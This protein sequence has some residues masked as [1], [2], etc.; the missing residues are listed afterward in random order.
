[1]YVDIRLIGIY[2]RRNPAMETKRLFSAMLCALMVLG[3]ATFTAAHSLTAKAVEP[4]TVYFNDIGGLWPAKNTATCE[5]DAVVDG[6]S[7]V[8]L[9]PDHDN[10]QSDKVVA[11][12]GAEGSFKKLNIE[13]KNYKYV[14]ISYKYTSSGTLPN[15]RINLGINKTGDYI[16]ASKYQ[17]SLNTMGKDAWCKAVFDIRSAVAPE[18]LTGSGTFC[19]IQLYPFGYNS[20]NDVSRDSVICFESITFLA[21]KPEVPDYKTPSETI[22]LSSYPDYAAASIVK[23]H[24]GIPNNKMTAD[25]EETTTDGIS[26]LK[27][28]PTPDKAQVDYV[29]VDG[30]Q[31]LPAKFNL[32]VYKYAAVLYK[33]ESDTP[34]EDTRMYM[35]LSANSGNALT[36]NISKVSNETLVEGKWA[37][38]TFN[39]ANLIPSALNPETGDHTLKQIY[40][41]P[42][43]QTKVSTID[44]GHISYL[45]QVMFFKEKPDFEVVRSYM[46]GYNDSTFRPTNKMTRAEACTIIARISAG[47]DDG[48]PA[49]TSSAYSDIVASGWYSK[50]VAYCEAKGF[51][52]YF[53]GTEF[54]PN[55]NI[56]RAEFVDLV[57]SMGLVSDNGNSDVF[58]DVSANHERYT[59]ITS[60]TSSGLVNGYKNIDGSSSFKPDN[61]I[62][63]AEVVKVIN[64]VLG[65]KV[66]IDSIS[67]DVPFIFP[68]VD[69][70]YWAYAE[71]AEACLNHIA[72]PGGNWLCSLIDLKTLLANVNYADD[73]DFAATDAYIAQLDATSAQRKEQIRNTATIVTVSG[74][75]YYVSNNGNDANDGLTPETAWATIAKVNSASLSPGDGVFFERGG[76]WRG[77]RLLA[78]T[79]VTYSAYGEGQKPTFYGSPENGAVAENWSLFHED[80]TTGKKIWVYNKEFT[81]VGAIIFNEGEKFSTKA[82]PNFLNGKYVLRNDITVDFDI[83]THLDKD[84]MIFSDLPSDGT[85]INVWSE[86]TIGKLYLRC[87]AGN[88]GTV[89]NSIEFNTRPVAIELG[90]NSDVTIDNLCIKYVGSHAIHAYDKT[91]SP[92]VE[93]IKNMTVTNCEIGWIGGGIQS[94]DGANGAVIRFGN[95]VELYGNCNT[96]RVE[97]CYVYQCYDAGMTHQRSKGGDEDTY[98]NNVTYRDNLIENCVYGIEYFLNEGNTGKETRIGDNILI[99]NNIIR[100]TGYGLGTQRPNTSVYAGIKGGTSASNRFTNF[101]IRNN[102]FD[103][104]ALNLVNTGTSVSNDYAPDYD[105]NTFIQFKDAQIGYYGTGDNMYMSMDVFAEYNIREVFGDK[106]AKIYF[107]RPQ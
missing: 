77:K 42:F 68:D 6:R 59:V 38:A 62:T 90:S 21:E 69:K 51:L 4:L 93:T 15:P 74:T 107:V 32:D 83:K 106:N 36:S 71:I 5:K 96:Y 85:T 31:Y 56:T 98:M 92:L 10:A 12:T 101:V 33:Y 64:T 50:Y 40:I 13:L 89:F 25:L 1:M 22:D 28:T 103:R 79:G 19:Q 80:S 11:S 70:S 63:R 48:V 44:S 37:I 24:N 3:C 55:Q 47:G 45:S 29:I 46:N 58:N 88:P 39:F 100:M 35:T 49:F 61:P 41:Y 76:L 67:S 65:R 14:E 2:Q 87:D 23:Y 91:N 7:C 30:W 57:Y 97:N 54:K 27:V 78:K 94:F 52:K 99:E 8:I 81:D 82:I 105:G 60:A 18:N 102:V 86:Y 73:E 104:S 53:T 43:G 26:A 72:I 16:K 84:L 95:G 9:K 75:K 17:D 20:I 66:S 34:L